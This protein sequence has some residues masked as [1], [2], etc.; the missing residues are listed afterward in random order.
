MNLIAKV[1]GITLVVLTLGT[2]ALADETFTVT[3]D[4]TIDGHAGTMLFIEEPGF[5]NQTIFAFDEGGLLRLYGFREG[6]SDIWDVLP[7][8]QY[9]VPTTTITAGMTWRFLDTEET[10]EE[11]QAEAIQRETVTTGAGTFLQAWRVDI[12]LASNPSK[13]IESQWFVEGVGLI[14]SVGYFDL[15]IEWEDSV[16]SY[17]VTGAGFMPLE[18]GN[19]WQWVTIAVPAAQTSVGSFKTR[20]GN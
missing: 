19:V 11:T 17:S 20:Y 6:G 18:P 16:D 14:K 9:L 4:T 12:S 1:I 8:A 5:G 15:W 3:A 7:T 2:A 13:V 10:G